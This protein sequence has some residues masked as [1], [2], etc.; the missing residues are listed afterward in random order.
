LTLHPDGG[1]SV[2][3]VVVELLYFEGCPN[4]EATDARLRDLAVECGFELRRRIVTR[5][6]EARQAGFRGSPTVLVDGVDAFASA[7]EPFS[8]SCRTYGVANGA[9]SIDQLRAAVCGCARVGGRAGSRPRE[10]SPRRSTAR[11]G[12]PCT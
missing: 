2:P 1:F 8:F 9:P 3:D 10:P 5:P 7:D 11:S 6:D 12:S 4:W